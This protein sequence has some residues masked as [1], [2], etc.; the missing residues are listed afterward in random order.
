[1]LYEV[2]TEKIVRSVAEEVFAEKG[3]KIDY[4]LGTMIEIPRA[5]LTAD[6]V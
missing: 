3:T 6:V 1:M 5:A 2:I 4:M